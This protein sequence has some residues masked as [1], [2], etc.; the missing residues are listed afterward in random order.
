MPAPTIA[1]GGSPPARC[2]TS[3]R[4][5]AGVG[6][7]GVGVAGV[8]APAFGEPA[9]GGCVGAADAAWTRTASVGVGAANDAAQSAASAATGWKV[10]AR[11]IWSDA[12]RGRRR[13]RALSRGCAHA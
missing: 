10:K 8:G 1:N 12:S 6:A 2:T 3:R 13:E 5:G 7:A 11:R 9:G 4:L